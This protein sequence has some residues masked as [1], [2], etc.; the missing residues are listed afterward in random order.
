MT[1]G[2]ERKQTLGEGS[3]GRE[4]SQKITKKE[5]ELAGRGGNVGKHLVGL[6][7]GLKRDPKHIADI[8]RRKAMSAQVTSAATEPIVTATL[9]G[10]GL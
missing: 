5:W 9:K 1:N 2:R 3:F 4:D 6:T 10:F 7:R 8:I